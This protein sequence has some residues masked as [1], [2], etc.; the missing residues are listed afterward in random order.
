MLI[1]VIIPTYNPNIQRL[2]QTLTGLKIQ[3]LPYK[4]WEL[5]IVDNNSSTVFTDKIDISWQPGSSIISE[6]R[7][8]LTYARLKGFSSAKGDI[9]VMVDDDNILQE[10]YLQQVSNIFEDNPKLGAAG[11]KSLPRFEAEQP[12]WLKEFYDSLAIRD[13]GDNV[14]MNQWENKYPEYA[15]IGAG[16]AIRKEAL[17]SYIDKIA[18]QTNAISDRTGTSLSSGGDND[19]VIEVLRSGWLTGYFPQLQ[20]RHIIP[21]ARTNSNYLARLVNNSNKSWMQLLDSHQINPWKKIPAWTSP[22]RKLKAWFTYKAWQNKL[23][24]IRWQ[25]ACGL[26]DGLAAIKNKA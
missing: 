16:M 7:Q 24:Y 4:F 1:S 5:L 10:D 14:V 13:L 19:I 9:I 25:G 15:P 23:N 22:L 6:P 2:E 17:T 18:N 20:L 8:G 12:A 21:A 11:G 3:S 26:F